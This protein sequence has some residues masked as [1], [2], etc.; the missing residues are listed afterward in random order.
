M[1]VMISLNTLIQNVNKK[2]A[3]LKIEYNTCHKA[4]TSVYQT[5][6]ISIDNSCIKFINTSD[7]HQKDLKIDISSI[8]MI[9]KLDNK[10]KI[11]T[12]D[13]ELEIKL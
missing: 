2:S 4:I 7:T 8:I 10:F 9:Q 3:K 5:L 11:I 6:S 13:C 12:D 1:T